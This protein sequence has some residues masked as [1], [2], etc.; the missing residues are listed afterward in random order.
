MPSYEQG[1]EQGFEQGCD[2]QYLLELGRVRDELPVRGNRLEL[3]NGLDRK[4]QNIDGVKLSK[5]D[6]ASDQ[7]ILD[8]LLV[9]IPVGRTM[10]RLFK[11]SF[12]ILTPPR[13][14]AEPDT[15]A[16]EECILWDL[17]ERVG[18]LAEWFCQEL[19][20]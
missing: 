12:D 15:L 2:D 5:L 16:L 7:S 18:V 8:T 3:V 6:S 1:F 19:W 17:V 9:R 20:R 14:R 10:R 13:T 4:Q 11:H